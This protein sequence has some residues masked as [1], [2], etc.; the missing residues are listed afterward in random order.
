MTE[1]IYMAI[2][3]NFDTKN[4]LNYLSKNQ[5]DIELN[6][7]NLDSYV[8]NSINYLRDNGYEHHDVFP[9]MDAAERFCNYMYGDKGHILEINSSS[10]KNLLMEN[11]GNKKTSKGAH[12]E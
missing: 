10:L 5:G 8:T 9:T 4:L 1:E 7:K 6:N 2:D 11:F 3:K 12:H